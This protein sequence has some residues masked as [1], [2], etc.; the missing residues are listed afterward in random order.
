ME[1]D[2]EFVAPAQKEIDAYVQN[3]LPVYAYSFDYAPE[4]T[5]HEIQQKTFPLFGKKDLV[6]N[7]TVLPLHGNRFCSWKLK[8]GFLYFRTQS[9]LLLDFLRS[10]FHS[11][12]NISGKQMEA[13]HGLGHAYIFTKGYAANMEVPNF[14]KDDEKMSTLLTD[15]VTN[16]AKY[17]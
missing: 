17:G 6:V 10:T 9:N 3:G 13:F 8:Q 2:I 15:I 14:G 7:R 16:F 5:V 11:L 12:T 4:F 1:S